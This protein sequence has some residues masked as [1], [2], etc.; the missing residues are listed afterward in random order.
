MVLTTLSDETAPATARNLLGRAERETSSSQTR[1]CIIEM[2][3]TIIVY[4]FTHLSRQ[5]IDAMLGV[6]IEDTRVYREAQEDKAKTIAINLLQQ[7]ISIEAIAQAT[8]L[9]IA[10]LQEM[11]SQFT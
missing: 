2:I 7:G 4:K 3:S 6:T 9:T 10:Q 1:Q 8:G 5:E 11:Q